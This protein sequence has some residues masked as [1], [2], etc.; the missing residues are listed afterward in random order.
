MIWAG[1]WQGVPVG[2]DG[3][4]LTGSHLAMA[5]EALLFVRWYTYRLPAIIHCRHLDILERFHGL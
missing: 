2:W 4:M 5:V 1:A 3:W